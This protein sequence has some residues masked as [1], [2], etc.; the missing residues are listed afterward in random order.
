MPMSSLN[1]LKRQHQ[2]I[3]ALIKDIETAINTKDIQQESFNFAMNI[4]ALAG[5]LL[6]HL[7]TEDRYLYPSL[8][9]HA[10]SKVRQLAEKFKTEMGGLAGQFTKY[11]ET[12]MIAGNIKNNPV[13]FT[14]DTAAVFSAIKS[15]VEAEEK[16]L[17]PLL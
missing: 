8:A 5:K 2:D 11:K 17:Y 9:A 10:D 7:S 13:Q 4:A 14:K 16:Q 1:I 3:A 12:Y 6:T 15:R